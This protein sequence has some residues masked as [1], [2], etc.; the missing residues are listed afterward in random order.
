MTLNNEEY[1]EQISPLLKELVE[2]NDKAIDIARNL[3][4][5]SIYSVDLY[6][7]GV[8]NR[9]LQLTDGFVAMMQSRNLTCGGA[10]LRLQLDNCI[11]VYALN[12]AEDSN[13]AALAV[14]KGEKLSK[15]R[16][17]NKKKLT[18]GYIK[19]QLSQYDSKFSIVYDNTSGYIHFS[20]KGIY[21]SLT[22]LKNDNFE[23]QVHHEA[24]EKSNVTLIECIHAYIHYTNFLYNM[25]EDAATAKAEFEKSKEEPPC[26]TST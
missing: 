8:L 21:Q 20:G 13:E 18:D 1:F 19:D 14:L 7:F 4:G 12:I 26:P 17:R 16:D 22:S 24:P 9:S 6:F 15:F 11:R 5:N 23:I 25:I 3:I 10:L 2:L